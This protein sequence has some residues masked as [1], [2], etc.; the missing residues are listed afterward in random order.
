MTDAPSSPPTDVEDTFHDVAQ[1]VRELSASGKNPS[2]AGLK[3]AL[4]RRHPSFTERNYGFKKFI[5]YLYAA[6][7]AG[8]LF[9]ARDEL[10]HPRISTTPISNASP[11]AFDTATVGQADRTVEPI[12]IRSDVWLSV[13]DWS[14]HAR[15]MWDRHTSRAFMFPTDTTGV[16]LW[17]SQPDRFVDIAP[18]DRDTHLKWM[19]EFARTL[20]V[21]QQEAILET[22]RE[23]AP[24]GQ[25]KRMLH[26]LGLERTWSDELQARAAE[27][28]RQWAEDHQVSSSRLFDKRPTKAVTATA[29]AR[30][31]A[32]ATP[33]P[34]DIAPEGRNDTE[35]LRAKLHRAIDTMT[36]TELSAIS[37]PA[38]YL[39]LE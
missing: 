17:E 18:I 24:R 1:I 30:H 11:A 21:E 12:K 5:D 25:Y 28:V 16:P 7:G 2:A 39:I 6:Q 22:L 31:S 13:I 37:V 23:D 20:P 9:V 26:Q 8:L 14:E 33:A 38:A 3:S 36:L 15:R 4:V 29:R 34:A 27:H 32:Q 35:R 19:D 10:G